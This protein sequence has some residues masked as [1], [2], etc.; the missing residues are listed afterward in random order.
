MKRESTL[1][2]VRNVI[3]RVRRGK[4]VLSS[5]RC[6]RLDNSTFYSALHEDE[7]LMKD[8][9][10]ARAN[11]FDELCDELRDDRQGRIFLAQRLFQDYAGKNVED[12]IKL[13]LPNA[14][15]RRLTETQIGWDAK[16]KALSDAFLNNMI[17]MWHFQQA[18]TA[19]KIAHPDQADDIN[20]LLNV[21]VQL[22]DNGRRR[23]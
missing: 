16:C 23:Q 15:R 7:E 13:G 2:R 6:E 3:E 14:L 5:I 17:T 11:G 22:P 12:Q 4:A 20:K 10:E 9:Q 21:T 18:L 19:I 8:Y 1:I